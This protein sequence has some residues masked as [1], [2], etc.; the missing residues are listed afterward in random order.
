MRSRKG[1]NPG[2][3][4]LQIYTHCVQLTFFDLY[5]FL[6]VILLYIYR[7]CDQWINS[8]PEEIL[9]F[10]KIFMSENMCAGNRCPFLQRY[11]IP[12]MR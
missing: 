4:A 5:I 1:S 10:I 2:K 6:F 7:P 3:V 12:A 9:K 8:Q 11:F